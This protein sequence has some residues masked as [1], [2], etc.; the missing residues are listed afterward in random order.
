MTKN[1]Y[2]TTTLPYVNAAPHIGFALELVQADVLARYHSFLGKKVFFNTGTDEHGLKIYCKAQEQKKSPQQFV[3]QSAKKFFQ[4]KELLN[5]TFNSFTRTTDKHHTDAARELWKICQKNGDIYLAK[6][7]NKYCVGCELEKTDSELINDRCP[8]HPNRD[9][10]IIEE[11]NYFFRFS[12]YQE[13][14]L[15]LYRDNPDF[16]LPRNKYNEIKKFVKRGL[17][18]F[19]IS[20]LKEKL[21][22]G[23]E[24]PGNPNHIMYVWF[25]ALINYISAIGWPDDLKKFNRW[26]PAVQLAGKDNLR[27]QAAMWQAMLISAGLPCSKQILIHGFITTDGQKMS[28][29]LGNVIDPFE[30]VAKYSTDAVRYYLLREIPPFKDGDFSYTRFA[31]LYNADLANNLGNLVSRIAK[32]A[33]TSGFSFSIPLVEKLLPTVAAALDSY[34]FDLALDT[35]WKEIIRINHQIDQSRPWELKEKKLKKELDS[36]ITAIINLIPCL[37]LFLP[38]TAKAIKKQLNGPKI[39]SGEPLFPR[40]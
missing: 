31:Q 14:L 15:D 32:L 22:W 21:P 10:E 9:L 33:E 5:L 12:K 17:K 35:I 19:S 18:D 28:K 6:Q 24:V 1:F 23:I 39:K 20:R 25:D 34:R 27:Q 26:W 11:E 13:K 4:L 38:E 40:I 36:L 3:D 29:S 30:L 16:I 2:L 8:L 7:K 37:S